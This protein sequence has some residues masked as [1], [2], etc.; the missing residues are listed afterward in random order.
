MGELLPMKTTPHKARFNAARLLKFVLIVSALA[1]RAAPSRV[2]D[3]P[4]LCCALISLES[5]AAALPPNGAPEPCDVPG[6][7]VTLP[8]KQLPL[9]H[10]LRRRL[11]KGMTAREFFELFGP[12]L[13]YIDSRKVE[14]T[15][16]DGSR[17]VIRLG[18]SIDALPMILIR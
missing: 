15:F 3:D 13:L 1:T 5:Q 8:E 7:V 18:R 16:D 2:L 12:G 4:S 6:L 17:F 14:W 11:T 9:D 10:V